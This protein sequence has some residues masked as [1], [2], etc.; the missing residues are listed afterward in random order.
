MTIMSVQAKKKNSKETTYH[1]LREHII[2]VS[3]Y[4]ENAFMGSFRQA[5]EKKWKT[6]DVNPKI[7]G[8][9]IEWLMGRRLTDPDG[10]EYIYK[11][12]M[13]AD[14]IQEIFTEI[15]DIYVFA[16][17]YNVPQLQRDA[18]NAFNKFQWDAPTMCSTSAVGHASSRLLNNSPLL[19]FLIDAYAFSCS[20]WKANSD[21]ASEATN[22]EWLELVPAEFFLAVLNRKGLPMERSPYQNLCDYH[23]YDVE[24]EVVAKP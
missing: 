9:F 16:D 3:E 5:G 1:I 2:S 8:V 12:E 14:K 7:F 11:K 4:F 21:A 18:M 23:E 20:D 15:L 24:E 13:R 19:R 10:V 6:K 17:E 22:I